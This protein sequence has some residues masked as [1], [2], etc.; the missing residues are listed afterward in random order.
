MKHHGH[1]DVITTF[2]ELASIGGLHGS[3]CFLGVRSG[4]FS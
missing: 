1:E 2:L 4:A 3:L